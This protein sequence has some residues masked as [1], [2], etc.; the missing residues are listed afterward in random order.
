MM[1][2]SV[3]LSTEQLT[4]SHTKGGS[5]KKF[6]ILFL[7]LALALVLAIIFLAL[8]VS[9]NKKND[10]LTVK[11][12]KLELEVEK[13]QHKEN[14]TTVPPKTVPTTKATTTPSG[15]MPFHNIRLPKTIKPSH[16]H[17]KLKV[18]M[19][20]S[21]VEG[22][23]DIVTTVEKATKYIMVHAYKFQNISVAVSKNG[24]NGKVELKTS[25]GGF[26][27]DLNQ[28]FVI[29]A[30]DIFEQGVYVLKF[31]Y[32][33]ILRKD[34]AG[35]YQS[36]YKTKNDEIRKVAATQF[37][38]VDARSALPCFDEPAMKAKFDV[39]IT[40][41]RDY[42]ALSNMP[43]V[44]T[45][46][47]PDNMM[48]DTFDTSPIMSTYL[49]AFVV[50][51]FANKTITTDS[52]NKVKMTYFAPEEQ[53]GQIDHA[54]TVG[55]KILPHFE[56]YY[57][58]KYPLPKAD[59]IAIPDFAAGAME[60]W[61]LITYRARALLYDDVASGV[62]NKLY[63]ASVVSHELAH[64]W[65][66][67][68]VTMDWWSDLWLNEG[69]ASYV[70]YI[71]MDKVH[72]EW[73]I[74]DFQV[75][76]DVARALN[77]DSLIS[78]HPIYIEVEKPSDIDEIFDA[79]SYSKGGSILRMLDNFLGNE[80]FVKGL[81]GYL[82][83]FSYSNAKTADLW[84]SL[85]NA[86][87]IH[88]DDVNVTDVMNSW[89]FQMGFPEVNI[90]DTGNGSF[91]FQQT[92]FLRDK[93]PDFSKEK[94]NSSYGYKWYIPFKYT[95]L[96]LNDKAKTVE[97]VN[98]TILKKMKY[99]NVSVQHNADIFIKGNAGQYGF[100]RVNYDTTGWTNIKKAL[101]YNHRVF[102]VKDRAGILGDAFALAN[103]GRIEYK[104]ALDL[105]DYINLD[106][107]YLPWK[108]ASDAIGF[109]PSVLT[110]TRPAQKKLSKYILQK[111]TPLFEKYQ[112]KD[113]KDFLERYLQVLV[114][115]LACGNGHIGCRNNATKLFKDW[116]EKGT[117]VPG[118]FRSMVYYYGIADSGIEAWD[119]M[120][121]KFE[122]N[123]IASEKTKLLYGLSAIKEPWALERYLFYALDE[124]KVKAQD[125]S[126]VFNYVA[127]YN[128]IGRTVAWNFLKENWDDIYTQFK[129]S[130][131]TLRRIFSGVTAGFTT[132]YE[133]DKMKEF[134][135]EKSP[136]NGVRIIQQ[137][138][139]KIKANIEWLNGNEKSID[140]WLTTKMI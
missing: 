130:F 63:V 125:T 120:F 126:Y 133:L 116:K 94:F 102:D 68:I 104:I 118:D 69:F 49:L 43:I 8:Y 91:K 24:T 53:I 32:N 88:G 111:V 135:K 15:K 140:D 9:S 17:L 90:I 92:R 110:S 101:K 61:G 57:G 89:I 75:I 27:Y 60:N 99:N 56:E 58:V 31:K 103:A 80:T 121:K 44:D 83:K 74:I 137:S 87:K 124:T 46:Y 106:T 78:S 98:S 73:K 95:T 117:P 82:N 10:E 79:I 30:V 23:C 115:S 93:N 52:S 65:F 64:Q 59:M 48:T 54:M 132:Q 35:F 119:W 22:S 134:I 129:D 122:I 3:N 70:E 107:D 38:P 127:N 37:E 128:S 6:T 12:G 25:T 51:D 28:Y 84:A 21:E 5:S 26:L 4:V 11:V 45:K 136:E 42:I 14:A 66:G 138:E 97:V 16:Y 39:Q 2:A 1:S 76:S 55:S 50:C 20:T 112:F 47:L 18:N 62:S 41:S 72:P 77:L 113:T 13:N 34:L 29:E 40:H 96:K 19:K 85:S 131:F 139:E 81:N 33:Y 67:N 109:I 71:G 105:F 123:K 114:V 7:L 108:A 36:T 100:F 86:S